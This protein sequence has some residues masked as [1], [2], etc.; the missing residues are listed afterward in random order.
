M[1]RNTN[2]QP[3]NPWTGD[4]IS[5]EENPAEAGVRS[6]EGAG[7]ESTSCGQVMMMMMVVVVVVVVVVLMILAGRKRIWFA[8]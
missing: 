5:L 3:L 8:C 7:A 2:P 4:G 6:M 1:T